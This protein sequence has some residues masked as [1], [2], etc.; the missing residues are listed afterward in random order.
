V[1]LSLPREGNNKCN[2]PLGTIC[3][4]ISAC[5]EDDGHDG[6]ISFAA[7]SNSHGVG[8]INSEPLGEMGSDYEMGSG[9][10]APPPAGTLAST[11]IQRMLPDAGGLMLVGSLAGGSHP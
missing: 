7:L 5:R 4:G 11:G 2:V 1:Q 6:D 3:P 9:S 8:W 10:V